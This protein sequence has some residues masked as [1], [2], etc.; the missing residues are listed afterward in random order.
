MMEKF[1]YG[2]SPA[3]NSSNPIPIEEPSVSCKM[4]S[5]NQQGSAGSSSSPKEDPFLGTHTV[6]KFRDF[7]S[8]LRFY[9]KSILADCRRSKN[10]RFH[11]FRG[12]DFFVKITLLIMSKFAKNS[13]SRAGSKIDFT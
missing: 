9:V 11:H 12:F 6:W 5:N 3:A 4:T 8:T 13:K 2:K 7:S 10:C 1:G